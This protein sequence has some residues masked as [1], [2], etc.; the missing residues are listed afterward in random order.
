MPQFFFFWR[1]FF[2]SGEKIKKT[3][4]NND[5]KKQKKKQKKKNNKK[6]KKKKKTNKLDSSLSFSKKILISLYLPLL[7]SVAFFEHYPQGA[8]FAVSGRIF[9][10]HRGWPGVAMVSCIL[11]HWGVQL[12]LAYSWARPA[13]IVAGKGTGARCVCGGGGGGGNVFISSVSSLSFLFSFFP[14]P[15]FHLF[16]LFSPFLWETTQNDPQGLTCC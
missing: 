6:K 2:F 14:V 8:G 1:K 7:Q 16:Y 12:I 15:L 4:K 11:R 9:N 13:I 10:L 5:K 3:T